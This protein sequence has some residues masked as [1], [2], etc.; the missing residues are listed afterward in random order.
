MEGINVRWMANGDPVF[1]VDYG[2]IHFSVNRTEA[3]SLAHRL[4]LAISEQDS[5]NLEA[6]LCG[7]CGLPLARH[8]SHRDPCP[9]APGMTR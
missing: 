1:F 6:P 8:S 2:H 7:L 5:K 9:K 4:L 3:Q